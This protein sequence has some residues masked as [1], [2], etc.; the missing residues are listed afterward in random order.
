MDKDTQDSGTTFSLTHTHTKKAIITII[1]TLSLSVAPPTSPTFV[2]SCINSHLFPTQATKRKKAAR[3]RTRTAAPTRTKRTSGAATKTKMR[4]KRRR[5]RRAAA[6]AERTGRHVTRK[7][8]SAATTTARTMT[9]AEPGEGG[10][11][12]AM[13]RT[14]RKRE[15]GRA[16]APHPPIAAAANRR[17]AEGR[18]AVTGGPTRATAATATEK[19]YILPQERTRPPSLVLHFLFIISRPPSLCHPFKKKK[20]EQAHKFLL[21]IFVCSFFVGVFITCN[22]PTALFSQHSCG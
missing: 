19:N 10:G 12:G 2:Y 4:R 7:R 13:T 14:Q 18:A 9:R 22:V 1:E 21:P 8:S 5:E 15:E 3:A 11:A 16:G 6:R 17:E 20:D